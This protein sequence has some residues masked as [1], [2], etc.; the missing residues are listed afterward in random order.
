MSEERAPITFHLE[1]LR[2][3]LIV[4]FAAWL[5]GS[6]ISYIYAEDIIAVLSAPAGKLYF[7]NPAEVFFSYLEVAAFTGFLGTLPIHCYEFWRFLRPALRGGE[8]TT[9]LW[10]IP[11]ALL[12]FYGGSAFAFFWVLPAAIQFFMG[13]ATV[14]LQ[15]MFSLSA[16]L[17]FFIA[18][19]LPFAL[20]FELPLI[21]LVLSRLGLVTA[22]MLKAKRRF[23]ILL[24]FI[25]AGVVSPTTDMFT[26]SCI[27]IP[28]IVLYEGTIVVIK[29]TERKSIRKD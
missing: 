22:A 29:M 18:F 2:R 26:Q 28:M 17:S 14:S 9:A 4:C 8:V 11:S 25:F 15:P 27:A 20:G 21:L 12:L 6:I 7:L 24:A 19:L 3:R 13:F 5:L 10:F 1:E 23:F 16:Y